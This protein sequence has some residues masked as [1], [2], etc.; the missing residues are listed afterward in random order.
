VHI[1]FHA[2]GQLLLYPWSYTRTPPTDRARYAATGDRLASAMFATHQVPYKLQ[3]G[4]ELY[5]AAGTMSDWAHG[6]AGALSFTIELRPS[7][8]GRG[9]GGFVLPPAQIKPTCDEGMAAVF[10]LRDAAP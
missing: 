8:G 6:E 9:A 5:A 10:A 1:D 3:S 4:A 2:Y 7:M